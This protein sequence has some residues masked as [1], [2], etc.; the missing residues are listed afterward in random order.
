MK[1]C[2]K[3]T[4]ENCCL[5]DLATQETVAI[6]WK[7]IGLYKLNGTSV[8]KEYLKKFKVCLAS[9]EYTNKDTWT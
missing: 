9:A 2:A 7:S 4:H 8:D 1:L 6:A 5:Q 3:F